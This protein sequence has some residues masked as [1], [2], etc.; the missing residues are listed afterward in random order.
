MYRG[1]LVRKKEEL[2][3]Y[4]TSGSLVEQ[5]SFGIFVNSS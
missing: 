5:I 2:A 3:V 4:K 1:I